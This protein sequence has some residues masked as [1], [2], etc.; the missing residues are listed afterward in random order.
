MS[1]KSSEKINGNTAELVIH[2]EKEDFD[3]AVTAEFKKE[4]PKITIPGFRKGKAPR[5]L[6]EKMYGKEAFYDG[7]LNSV[8]PGEYYSAISESEFKP[9]S[10]PEYE[11]LEIGA[12]GVEV[13]ATVHILPEITVKDYKG[14]TVEKEEVKVTEDDVNEKVE[15]ARRRNS[16]RVTADRPAQ[17]GDTANIDYKGTVDGVEFDGGSAENHDLKLGSGTFIP[18]FEDQIVGHSAGEEFDVNVTF[19]EDYHAKELAGKAAV[20]AVKLNEVTTEEL[21]ELDDEFAKDVSEFDTLAEYRADVEKKLMETRTQAAENAAINKAFEKLVSPDCFEADIPDCMIDDEVQNQIR[22]MD[23][24][25]RRSG[26]NISD[27]MKYTGMT[28]DQLKAQYRGRA[29][30]QLKTRLALDQIAKNEGLEV[31]EDDFNGEIKYLA[32]TY[33]MTE[34]EVKSQV[35][36]EMVNESVLR[37]KASDLVKENIV[38]TATSAKE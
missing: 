6:V 29:T 7:A 25:M 22:D 33:S 16:R 8:I 10:A 26:L 32:E 1:L 3:K 31:S 27:Y 23:F 35:D 9:V 2:I 4:S 15:E 18:G 28:M 20:F 19:P 30:D 37:R 38:Y 24:N 21:P 17:N 12:D 13:K 14:I 36:P 11:V 34:D 5:A